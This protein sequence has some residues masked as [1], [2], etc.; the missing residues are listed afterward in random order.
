MSAYGTARTIAILLV[1]AGCGGDAPPAAGGG[2]PRGGDENRPIP[3]EVV[4]VER[5][6]IPR[7]TVVASQLEP[8]RS[9]G[10]NARIAGPLLTVRVREGDRVVPGQVLAEIDVTELSA[11]VR[12]ARA[13]LDF[14]QSTMTRSEAL[15]RE[16]IITAAEYERDRA[17]LASARAS[18]EQLEAREGYAAVAAPIAGVITEKLV[19]QGDVVGNQDRL[20]TIADISLLVL[21]VP[22]SELEVTALQV[23]SQADLTV[24]ALGGERFD[25]RIRRIFPAADSSTRLVPVEVAVSGDATQRLRPGY[26]ARVTFQLDSRTDALLIPT[27][28]V[29]GPAGSRSVYIARGGLAERRPVRVGTDVDG[30]TEVFEGLVAGDSIIVAGNAMVRDGGPIRIVPPLTDAPPTSASPVGA[31]TD[32]TAPAAASA[33]GTQA[34]AAR[35]AP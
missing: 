27:R 19:E 24:D 6:T 10:V 4:T 8:V 33:G 9:V 23:G 17:A 21:R 29:M 20:F 2:G 31:T 5:G 12:S 13:S 7:T 34:T 16:R 22:V 35:T 26:T 3:V 14:A 30:R 15:W 28:A 18:L 11:Q 1:A 32:S 25:G